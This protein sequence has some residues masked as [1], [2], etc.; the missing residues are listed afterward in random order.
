[1]KSMKARSGAGELTAHAGVSQQRSHSLV[2]SLAVA[3][4]TL[5]AWPFGAL[6]RRWRKT[7][8]SEDRGN[9]RR[10]LTARLVLLVD[11][12]VIVATATLYITATRDPTILNDALDPLLGA[13]YGFAWLGVAGA[14]LNLG[15]TTL[16]W[17][18]GT[19]TRW[20]RVHHALIA[21]SSVMIAWFFATFRIAGTTFNY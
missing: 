3:L 8:W 12:A 5:L 17:R 19:G 6:W 21:A 14:I 16:F 11:V 18:N 10:Y 20:F 2:A 4:L 9:R 15:A 7:R 13:L 1:M